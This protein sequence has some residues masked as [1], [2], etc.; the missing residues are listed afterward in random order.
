MTVCYIT[1]AV[2][3]R[4]GSKFDIPWK[5]SFECKRIANSKES[6]QIRTNVT[7]RG[8]QDILPK[9]TLKRTKF[10]SIPRGSKVQA[11]A[12]SH[13]GFL[14]TANNFI[15]GEIVCLSSGIAEF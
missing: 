8:S 13:K 1:N 15:T 9:L 5:T 10:N 2:F 14:H 4:N 12:Q 11:I 6:R 3:E 7:F